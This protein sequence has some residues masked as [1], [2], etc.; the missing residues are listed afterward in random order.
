MQAT[1]PEAVD[2]N[3]ETAETKRLYGLDDPR[4]REF[5]AMCLRAR[6]LVERGVR[7]VQ[8]YCGSGS[9][10]DAH[11]DIEGN[12]GKLCARSDR[13]VAALITDLKRRGL[14]DQTLVI[15]G[16]EF[17]RTPMNEKTDG[18]DH[19]PYGFS[20]FFAGGGAKGGVTHGTT[21]EF[22]LRAVDDR[23]HVH[24]LHA[25]ILHLLGLDHRRLTFPRD[26]RDERMTVNG[27]RVVREI[28]A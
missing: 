5:G 1:A 6:R 10:W 4:C 18:R 11:R 3:G 19:N 8:L 13:P 24:D 14:L 7:F 25:T 22:G 21:D 26:G 20:M 23:V 9:Q 2:L 15:W 17:G 27:G 28:L 12:H 16:G